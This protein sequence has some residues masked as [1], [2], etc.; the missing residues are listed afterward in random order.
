MTTPVPSDQA[1]ITGWWVGPEL[2]PVPGRPAPLALRL[3]ARLIDAALVVMI[4]IGLFATAL[5]I[6]SS[7]SFLSSVL[8]LLAITQSLAYEFVLTAVFGQTAGK[9][10]L[11]LKVVLLSGEPVTWSAA[12]LRTIPWYVA[13][14]CTLGLLGFVQALSPLFDTEVW[15]RGWPDKLAKTVVVHQ[16]L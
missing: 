6:E 5:A 8:I 4:A 14:S 10:L 16:K 7:D 13:S 9:M 11:K 3:V 2:A 1:A 12:A 15:H